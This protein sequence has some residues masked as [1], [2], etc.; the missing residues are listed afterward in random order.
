MAIQR[1]HLHQQSQLQLQW[2]TAAVLSNVPSGTSQD[3]NRTGLPEL[4][5]SSGSSC[6]S[7]TAVTIDS[8]A[9]TCL[10]LLGLADSDQT[11]T[12]S[13]ETPRVPAH[14]LM[15]NKDDPVVTVPSSGTKPLPDG[16]TF[17]IMRSTTP[18]KGDM[19]PGNITQ[20]TQSFA[21]IKP[22]LLYGG[23]VLIVL[24]FVSCTMMN[25]RNSS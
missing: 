4:V 23:I 5:F 1:L 10:H 14:Q 15:H 20:L 2:Q 3:W 11:L 18:P 22:Y 6:S 8:T 13:A 16:T 12:V 19:A 7:P 21:D 25:R 17:T 9:S 24:S